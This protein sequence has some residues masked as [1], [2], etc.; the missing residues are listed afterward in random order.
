MNTSAVIDTGSGTPLLLLHGAESGAGQYLDLIEA[1]PGWIRCLSYDQRDTGADEASGPYGLSD[2]AD[3]AAAL[4]DALGLAEAHVLGTSFGGAV[5]QHLAL[6]HPSR[7]R[8][9]I[10]VAT[11]AS[12]GPVRDYLSRSRA[13]PDDQRRQWLI[14]GAIS[15]RG[16]RDPA[17][18]V[19]VQASVVERTAEQRSRRLGALAAHD[20]TE[21][22]GRIAAPTLVIH[23]DDDPVIPLSSGRFLARTIP[24]AELAVVAGGRHALA[25]E[26]RDET[27]ALVAAFVARN[28]SSAGVEGTGPR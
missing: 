18:L 13:V 12:P 3:D 20:T 21:L 10:L 23:G 2:L 9:L 24:G 22:L 16:Q 11:T 15:S 26:R 19:R 25:F 17:L 28:E 14:D 6:R 1:L 27:A 5:A 4:L 7:V 8:S